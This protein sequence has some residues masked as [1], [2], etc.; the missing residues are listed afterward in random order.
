MASVVET[1]GHTP[2]GQRDS[3]RL[4]VSGND[5]NVSGN[6]KTRDGTLGDPVSAGLIIRIPRAERIFR[7]SL[8]EN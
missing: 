7:D 3:E 4:H 1:R 8:D 5:K 2:A 6:G